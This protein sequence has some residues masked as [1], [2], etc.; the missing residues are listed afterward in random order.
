MIPAT[1]L[2]DTADPN[3]LVS[4]AD[5]QRITRDTVTDD[6]DVQA[7]IDDALDMCQREMRR[8][9]LYAQYTERLYLYKNGMVYPSATPF[10]VSKVVMSPNGDPSDD[11]GIFQGA[12]IWVGWFVPLPSLP[13]WM[14][15]VSPQTDI[16][17][18]GG[19]T[20]PDGPGPQ[21][22]AKL[23]RIIARVAWYVA[24]P[25]TL[26]G[27][28]GGVKSTSAGGVSISGDLSSM[29]AADPQLGRDIARYRKPQARGWGGQ[30]TPA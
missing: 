21:I 2:P 24:N 12:G 30:T 29:V 27:L 18:W 13:V 3:P 1:P 6:D 4:V 9:I 15:V 22:P 7:A 23:A 5:Y 16:T 8:T 14:G 11:V 25:A 26:Q 10:D 28:P 20:G 19:F 17:Y